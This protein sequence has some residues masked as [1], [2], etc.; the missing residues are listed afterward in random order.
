[1]KSALIIGIAIFIAIVTVGV[2]ARSGIL[3]AGASEGS[4][5]QVQINGPSGGWTYIIKDSRH[6]IT[7]YESTAGSGTYNLDLQRK[8]RSLFVERAKEGR[9]WDFNGIS[10]PRWKST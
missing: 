5:P 2:A 6:D 1:M 10:S 3:I 9:I 8:H 7:T 4:P